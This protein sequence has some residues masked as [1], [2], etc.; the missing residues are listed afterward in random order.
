MKKISLDINDAAKKQF[1]LVITLT[2]LREFKIRCWLVLK[3]IGL[4]ALVAPFSVEI[5]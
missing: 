3:L 1:T 5:K 2:G 4:L